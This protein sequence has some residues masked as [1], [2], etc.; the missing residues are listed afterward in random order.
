MPDTVF[1][2]K[3]KRCSNWW[4]NPSSVRKNFLDV[5]M[6][7]RDGHYLPWNIRSSHSHDKLAFLWTKGLDRATESLM[8]WKGVWA[9]RGNSR[10]AQAEQACDITKPFPT[11]PWPWGPLDRRG[12]QRRPILHS[13]PTADQKPLT[14]SLTKAGHQV[15]LDFWGFWSVRLI[16]N[17]SLAFNSLPTVITTLRELVYE[18]AAKCSCWHFSIYT[19]LLGL[20]MYL[21]LHCFLLLSI[22]THFLKL[23]IFNVIVNI[24][25]FQK[26]VVSMTPVMV[27]PF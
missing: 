6:F 19:S 1:H 26:A 18:K 7:W 12:A 21:A 14:L 16:E 4:C 10:A 24:N 8:Q 17:S 9:G 15:K 20:Q 5:N 2:C 25:I 23:S 27:Y 13:T 3:S 11:D 22:N